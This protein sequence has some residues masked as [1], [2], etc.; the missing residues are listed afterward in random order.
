MEHPHLKIKRLLE[1]FWLKYGISGH[2]SKSTL[3]GKRYSALKDLKKLAETKIH[4]KHKMPLAHYRQAFNEVKFKRHNLY[5]HYACFVCD[6]P[7]DVRHHIISLKNGGINSKRNLV[8][9]CSK[10][11]AEV[12]PWLREEESEYEDFVRVI[13]NNKS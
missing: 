7:G 6:Y 13:N 2:K 1:G 4:Y 9:L 10:C 12:H 3:P 5:T 11:H 8:T